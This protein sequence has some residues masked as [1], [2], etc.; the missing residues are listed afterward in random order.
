MDF[1]SIVVELY[2]CFV[3]IL[4]APT[5]I[6]GQFNAVISSVNFLINRLLLKHFNKNKITHFTGFQ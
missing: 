6:D 4:Q 1:Q 2:V 5:L 3:W